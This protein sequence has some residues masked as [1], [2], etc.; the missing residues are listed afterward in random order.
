MKLFNELAVQMW[1]SK[2]KVMQSKNSL[3][4]AVRTK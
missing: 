1:L 2:V 4:Y 3:D